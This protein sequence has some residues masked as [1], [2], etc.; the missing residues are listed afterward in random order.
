MR[1]DGALPG[2][3]GLSE[4]LH[5]GGGRGAVITEC[6]GLPFPEC[7]AAVE[8][9]HSAP[10]GEAAGRCPGLFFSSGCGGA[11][12]LVLVSAPTAL[13][14]GSADALCEGPDRQRV[15]LCRP[16]GLS[17][18]LGSAVQWESSRGQCVMNGRGCV[19]IKLYAQAGWWAALGLRARPQFGSLCSRFPAQKEFAD[20]SVA[21]GAHCP[22]SKPSFGNAASC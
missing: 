18:L 15:L 13:G 22:P 16:Q 11:A 7:P 1:Q 5:Q 20:V 19:P 14:Q 10:W 17:R 2:A 3:E 6:C 9:P 12:S 4:V 8:G 21:P